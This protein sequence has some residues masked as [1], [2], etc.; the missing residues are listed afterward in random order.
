MSLTPPPL[1][2]P[3][4]FPSLPAADAPHLLIVDDDDRIRDLLKRYLLR[5]GFLVTAARDA[6][7]ARRLLAG[8]AFDLLVLDVM[9]PGE[10]GLALTRDLR[11]RAGG[12]GQVPV[13]LLTARGE[14]QDRIAGFEAGADDYLPKPF[15]PRELVLRINAI[16][17]RA[18]RS[19][20]ET[21][22]PAVLQLGRLRYEPA[23]GELS[24]GTEPVR[25]TQTEAALLRILAARANQPIRREELVELLGRDRGP[26]GEAT[27]E[28]AVDVQVTRLRRK[29]EP[30]PRSPRFLQT[31][32]GEGYMLATGA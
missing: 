14:A 21:A 28:R 5:Q 31:V 11:G 19:E 17:R 4:S 27:Q 32:R 8:L 10:D 13:I 20:P 16:L 3:S 24:D 30:E 7:Q 25:L 29:L 15:E 22:V 18:P 1:S 6:G 12:A 23:T 2:A 9:M 26:G